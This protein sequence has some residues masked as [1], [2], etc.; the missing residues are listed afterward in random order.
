M[1]RMKKGL[2]L[3]VAVALACSVAAAQVP[4]GRFI[5]KVV[6]EQGSPLPGVAVQ[7]T[8]PRLVGTAATVT[9]ATGTYRVFSLPSGEYTKSGS[10]DDWIFGHFPNTMVMFGIPRRL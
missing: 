5:G 8:S 7:A 6:D 1:M 2:F 3:L 4:T 9:D 10:A